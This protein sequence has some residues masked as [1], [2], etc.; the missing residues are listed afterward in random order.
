MNL[1]YNKLIINIIKGKWGYCNSRKKIIAL[2]TNLIKRS[3]FEIDYV[4]VHELA[5][6]V[7]P[8]HSKNFYQMVERYFKDYKKAEKMLK[9]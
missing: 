6:L 1:D 9:L 7:H 8:N 3:L 2:N 5:H 4:I